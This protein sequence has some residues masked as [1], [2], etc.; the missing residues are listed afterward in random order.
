MATNLYP[1]DDYIEGTAGNDTIDGGV[2]YDNLVGGAGDDLLLGGES[3][4]WLYGGDGNDVLVG[5]SGN[6]VL[7][8]GGG[9]DTLQGGLGDDRY[10]WSIGLSGAY[11]G[12]TEGNNVIADTGG[13]DELDLMYIN[14]VIAL[15]RAGDD[16][17][18]SAD[19]KTM[20]IRDYFVTGENGGHIEK[21]IV[22]CNVWDLQYV[23]DHLSPQNPGEEPTPP[24]PG[25]DP[26]QRPVA[27]TPGDNVPDVTATNNVDGA[28]VVLQANERTQV[29]ASRGKDVL[30]GGT[31]DDTFHFANGG[32]GKMRDVIT[33]FAPGSDKIDLSGIDA[34]VK[35]TG[36]N[37]FHTLL[38][39]KSAFT[40]AGQLH[41]DQKTG[42][43]S[44]NTDKD[45]AAEF[46]IILKN[47]PMMLAL[48][49]FIL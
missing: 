3:D 44:G 25:T 9:N 30:T 7:G 37:A 14:S 36:D 28:T 35:A 39:G 21:I 16:L 29:W 43:L 8:G 45:A 33:D 27:N 13:S 1:D 40:K 47:K 34:N 31:G 18:L 11:G 48:H 6:D 15:N 19:G 20:T 22:K 41:Y 23:L 4:D 26:S 24:V 42:I 10:V 46:Q 5:G 49:D 2:G 12:E 32:L 17:I 38:K